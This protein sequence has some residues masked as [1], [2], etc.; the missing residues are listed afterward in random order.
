MPCVYLD[1]ELD[2]NNNITG[3]YRISIDINRKL[4]WAGN[5]NKLEPY[6]HIKVLN[7]QG[8]KTILLK[9]FEKYK[10]ENKDRDWL[11]LPSL[12]L[13]E[14]LI[15]M[16]EYKEERIDNTYQSSSSPSS[17]SGIGGCIMTLGILFI[18]A[19][20]CGNPPNN[21]ISQKQ[22]GTTSTKWTAI[23]DSRL[24]NDTYTEVNIRSDHTKNSKQIGKLKNGTPIF[25]SKKSDG[26]VEIVL[27]DGSKGWVAGNVI[28]KE[29]RK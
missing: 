25:I 15:M 17:D 5:P 27:D 10:N 14:V 9:E 18:I 22:K 24:L 28:K 8:T 16:N 7:G 20:V 4:S 11:Y 12:E 13:D 2:G 29:R 26:W 21:T 6:H 23:V 19:V 1:R 3:S